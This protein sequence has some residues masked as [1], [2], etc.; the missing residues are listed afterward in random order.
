LFSPPIARIEEY[1]VTEV[2]TCAY[3]FTA[4]EIPGPGKGKMPDRVGL[5][6]V[7]RP[8]RAPVDLPTP[9]VSAE[10]TLN[11]ITHL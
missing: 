5:F 9:A 1:R 10:M 4:D 11:S 3:P 2:V 8:R 7:V 6:R